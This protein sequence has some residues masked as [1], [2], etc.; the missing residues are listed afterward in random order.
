[1]S[2]LWL[3]ELLFNVSFPSEAPWLLTKEPITATSCFIVFLVCF[4]VSLH[5]SVEQ[6]SFIRLHNL[7]CQ[8]FADI[9]HDAIQPLRMPLHSVVVHAEISSFL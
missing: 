4:A 8:E 7:F 2:Y 5:C 1:M 9:F 3:S 6:K